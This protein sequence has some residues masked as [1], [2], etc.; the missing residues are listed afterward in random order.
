M[1]TLIVYL[2]ITILFIAHEA[3][4]QED[5]LAK[6]EP[7]KVTRISGGITFDGIPDEAVWQSIEPLPLTMFYPVPG[8]EPTEISLIRIAYDDEYFYVSGILNYR[9]TC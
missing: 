5:D 8:N 9:D 4:G 7:L 1:K 3:T 6:K 2:C